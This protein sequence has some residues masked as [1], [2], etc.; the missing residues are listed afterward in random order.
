MGVVAGQ[1]I[2]SRK[3]TDKNKASK[4]V[5]SAL[6]SKRVRDA[7]TE[8][9]ARCEQEIDLLVKYANTDDEEHLAMYQALRARRKGQ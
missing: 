7:L 9:T 5:K 6:E 2:W 3:S 8:Q 4:T 1:W